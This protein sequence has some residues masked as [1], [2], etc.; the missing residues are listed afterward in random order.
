[1][2]AHADADSH[3]NNTGWHEGRDPSFFLSTNIYLSANPDV[4]AAGGNPLDH[5]DS[6]GWQE[7][8]ITFRTIPTLR[9][10][11]SIRSCTFR[12]WVGTK[13][14]IRMRCSTSTAIARPMATSRRPESIRS[15]ITICSD[16]TRGAIR[17]S[18][19]TRRPIWRLTPTWAATHVNPLTHF[20]QFGVH[21]G[22]S[23]FADGVW[24]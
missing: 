15:T 17:R 11:M 5:F 1:M 23:P 24:G 18:A 13:G 6:I 19:S 3:F 2:V 4:R 14:A 8:R 20:L 21:E 10:R 9:R 16:G 22:R 7:K 12:P